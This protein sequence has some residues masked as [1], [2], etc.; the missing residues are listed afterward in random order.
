[1]SV[2][3]IN[4]SVN[5]GISPAHGVT[6]SST[7]PPPNNNMGSARVNR[8]QSSDLSSSSSHSNSSN[9]QGNFGCSPG[10]QIVANVA[11][12]QGQAGSQSSNPSLNLNNSS[13]EG[14]GISLA[15][16]M[17]PRRQANSGLA[18]RAR[19]SNKSFPPNIPTVS[20]P[21]GSSSGACNINND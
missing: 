5:P 17:S 2:P 4:P 1:M 16:F 11:L 18:T 15:Q 8:Q 21:V 10:N 20:S 7:L 13:M 12:N 9:N 6:R 19:M 3:R 14:T